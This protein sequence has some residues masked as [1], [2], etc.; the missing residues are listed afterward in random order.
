MRSARPGR[1]RSSQQLPPWPSPSRPTS[2]WERYCDAKYKHWHVR[3][4]CRREHWN[5]ELL[6]V[7]F[8]GTFWG[9]VGFQFKSFH[10]VF[11][12][13]TRT[14]STDLLECPCTIRLTVQTFSQVGGWM[15]KTECL[16]QRWDDWLGK[17]WMTHFGLVPPPKS[18]SF[19]GFYDPRVHRLGNPT[20]LMPIMLPENHQRR[21]TLWA[22][23]CKWQIGF[24]LWSCH[25]CHKRWFYPLDWRWHQKLT[26]S[27]HHN[28]WQA[29]KH[30]L[31]VCLMFNAVRKYACDMCSIFQLPTMVCSANII[32]CN[33]RPTSENDNDSSRSR[34]KLFQWKSPLFF[35][36]VAPET[37][38]SRGLPA[39]ST[40]LAEGIWS[41]NN[42]HLV[43]EQYMKFPPTSSFLI[44]SNNTPIL[45]EIFSISNLFKLNLRL[46]AFPFRPNFLLQLH[47]D[48]VGT[49][50]FVTSSPHASFPDFTTWSWRDQD[51][52]SL[53]HS[54]LSINGNKSP[55][56]EKIGE[57]R[58][59][60]LTNYQKVGFEKRFKLLPPTMH[61]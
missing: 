47:T 56:K 14:T 59:F 36:H 39:T 23:H 7:Q 18:C 5:W 54:V 38:F 13:N 41:E 48:K 30:L 58:D 55:N 57:T 26:S 52:S 8:C 2:E 6:G 3:F 33:F 35:S 53:F 50:S 16:L 31:F 24:H 40:S 20:R 49:A 32:F 44:N 51:F 27:H 1:T 42:Y 10:S 60:K 17:I 43:V 4:V 37:K 25:K 22:V 28:L 46:I 9:H 45:R 12:G 61:G 19:R 34:S 11:K 21:E 15:R 29:W